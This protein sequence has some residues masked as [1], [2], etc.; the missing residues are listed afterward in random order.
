MPL[1]WDRPDGKKIE[2]AVNR[3]RAS[4]PEKR[5]GSMFVNPGGPG[6][7][8]VELV[9]T[10]GADFDAWGGGRF[11]VVGWDPR[12]TNASSPVDCFT[13][14]AARDRFW[15]G[16]TIPITTP[17]RGPSDARPSRWP[18]GAVGSTGTS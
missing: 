15:G 17:S 5:I 18:A 8:G 11:D 7:S 6:E 13:S 4:R 9:G 10:G 2:L 16:A 3:H 12:G 14:T 1:D